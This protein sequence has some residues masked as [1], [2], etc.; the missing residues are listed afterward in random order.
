MP[1][2]IT[3]SS[4]ITKLYGVG[5][6][7]QTK[8]S[9]LGVKTVRDLLEL[10]PHRAEDRTNLC[11]IKDLKIQDEAVIHGTITRVSARMSKRGVLVIEARVKDNS[12]SINAVWF[13]QRYL[14]KNLEEG[15]SI[16]LYG[17]KRIVPT[18]GNP[19]FVKKIIS[20]LEIAPIYPGTSGLNQATISR[21]ISQ[22]RPLLTSIKDIIPPKVVTELGLP[23]RRLAL[24]AAHFSPNEKTLEQARKLLGFEELFILCLQALVAKESRQEDRAM[25]IKPE[26]KEI[27]RIKSSVGFD[28]TASQ[29]EVL[30][31]VISDLSESYPMNRLLY[32][33]VGSGKTAVGLIAAAMVARRG[34]KVVWLSPTTALANQ[35]ARLTGEYC[36]KLQLTCSLLTGHHKDPHEKASV[37][38]GTHVLLQEKVTLGDVGLVVIDEQHRFGVDQRNFLLKN[39][40][41]AH[42]LMLSAT[43]IPRTLAHTLFGHLDV[44]YLTEK[45]SHQ[46]PIETYVFEDDERE[47]VEAHINKRLESKQQGYIICP[48]I[49]P[50]GNTTTLFQ[51]E[52]K[53][54]TTELKRVEEAH[55]T[56]KVGLLHGRLKQEDKEA[57]MQGFMEG[58]IDILLSTSVV[59]VGIDNKNA[60]WILIEEADCFGLSQLHQ[61]RGRVGRGERPSVC[62]LQNSQ[63]TEHATE[64]LKALRNAKDGLE[65]AEFDLKFRGPGNI[66]GYEQ[67]GLP[68]LRYADL[69]D[70]GEIKKAYTAAKEIMDEGLSK[71][72]LLTKQLKNG[73]E[74]GLA[75]A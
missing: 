68:N 75:A 59:E 34:K 33:E 10:L 13:N 15:Q 5:E 64:R 49:N 2:P 16:S 43:P 56:A 12:G 73:Q 36:N 66:A 37:I 65:I 29:E 3:L 17:A 20:N 58:E 57:V 71:Y 28:L 47:K 22:V 46:K 61:L 26:G 7:V 40:P 35:Q 72:P 67:S 11:L 9:K 4:S 48:L 52:R 41:H 19:F 44:S 53:A 27:A 45:P 50:T 8:L 62:F 30:S 31:E 51:S 42:L 54:V 18:M 69:N 60:T 1:E 74:N 6:Q 55:P 63:T 25:S 70:L 32:G 23:S 14:L 38:V 21:L 39:H 24:E